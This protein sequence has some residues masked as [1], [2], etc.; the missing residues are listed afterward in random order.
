MVIW[1]MTYVVGIF[2]VSVGLVMFDQLVD[3][4]VVQ[5]ELPSIT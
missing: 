1:I 5:E 2:E 4:L 3:F